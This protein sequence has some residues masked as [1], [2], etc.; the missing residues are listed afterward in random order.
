MGMSLALQTVFFFTV[1]Q[2]VERGDPYPQEVA[3]TV[4]RVMETLNTSHPYRLVWQS[5]V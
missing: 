2:V 5:K 3:A 1:G 4:Q